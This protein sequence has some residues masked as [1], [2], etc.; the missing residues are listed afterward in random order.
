VID[1]HQE[2]KSRV[3]SDRS[4]GS[5]LVFERLWHELGIGELIGQVLDI[6]WRFEFD[7]E[8]LVFLTALQRLM[9]SAPAEPRMSANRTS[10]SQGPKRLSYVS[11]TAPLGSWG[12]RY[13][14]RDVKSVLESR[15]IYNKD[16]D[17]I[18]GRVFCSL[19]AEMLMKELRSGLG[20]A[21]KVL[22][23]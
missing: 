4:I 7:V 23:W 18:R 21:S 6:D 11:F 9:V 1:R 8:W 10:V 14:C 20:F 5:A 15:P 13:A 2:G 3:H 19:L 16:G 17:T 12:S 22:R